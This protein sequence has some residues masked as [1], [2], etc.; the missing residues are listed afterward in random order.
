MSNK[1]GKR[2]GAGNFSPYKQPTVQVNLTVPASK[3][4]EFREYAKAKLSE[5]KTESKTDKNKS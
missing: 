3:E 1:G 4:K 2:A 5:W